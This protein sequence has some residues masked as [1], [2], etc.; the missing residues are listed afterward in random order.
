MEHSKTLII[1]LL[2]LEKT[3]DSPPITYRN[4]DL[5]FRMTGKFISLSQGAPRPTAGF[6][7]I[8]NI[9]SYCS[10]YRRELPAQEMAYIVQVHKQSISRLPCKITLLR[11]AEPRHTAAAVGECVCQRFF[12][13]S[14]EAAEEIPWSLQPGRGFPIDNPDKRRGNHEEKTVTYLLYYWSHFAVHT[15]HLERKRV[16]GRKRRHGSQ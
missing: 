6:L 10:T 2:D 9:P 12:A 8:V 1:H 16:Y 15:C 11:H 3:P 14:T 4:S 7:D 5:F 13:S